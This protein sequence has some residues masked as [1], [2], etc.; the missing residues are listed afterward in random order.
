MKHLISPLDFSV[1]ELDQ[2]DG[3]WRNDIEAQSGKICT[4][5]RG[6][7]TCNFIL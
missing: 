3:S 6:Q 2:H 1:E 7:K 4:C 5:L